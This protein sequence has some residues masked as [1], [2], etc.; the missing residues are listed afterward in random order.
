MN[1]NHNSTNLSH[2]S[3]PS[4]LRSHSTKQKLQKRWPNRPEKALELK[5]MMMVKN[6]S[7]YSIGASPFAHSR[8]RHL[9]TFERCTRTSLQERSNLDRRVSV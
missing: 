5:T 7:R 8:A 9:L 1:H 3:M 2:C 6:S 4:V